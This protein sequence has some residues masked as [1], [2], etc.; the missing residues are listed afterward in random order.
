MSTSMPD[1]AGPPTGAATARPGALGRYLR[2]PKGALTVAFIPLL[3]A[4]GNA[5]GWST[6]LPQV[7]TA[8]A[9]ACL[10]ELLVWKVDG[11]AR[12]VP[13]SALLSGLI[14]AF[15]LGLETPWPVTLAVGSLATASKYLLRT[16]RG[17][18]FN[19][20]ALALLAAIPLFGTGQSWWG[21][22]PDLPW[23]WL[24]LLLV[25][26]AWVVDRIDK[27]PL[28]LSFGAAYFGLLTAVALANPARVAEVFRTPFVQAA[29]FFAF[30]MLT[31]PPTA[32]GRSAEQVRIGVLV[33]A[34][35]CLALL[36]GAGEAYLP[37]GL[38]V[39]NLALAARQLARS[40]R[41]VEAS[42][43]D[44]RRADEGARGPSRPRTPDSRRGSTASAGG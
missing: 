17:H 4:A 25:G 35:A 36:L 13:T 26:G 27:F 2:T 30:F 38:L 44:S 7:A 32:P 8:V 43:A 31:D 42:L 37:V 10:V 3:A 21:A 6:V 18:V 29:L 14:V 23:P 34:V 1:R 28:V 16:R 11:G 19:P 33:A 5:L 24:L 9:G 22:L 12:R 41:P 39:G 20:A 40:G 15:V